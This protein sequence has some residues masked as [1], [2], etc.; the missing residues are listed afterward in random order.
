MD[1]AHGSFFS[2]VIV[3]N[4]NSYNGASRMLQFIADGQCAGDCK[5]EWLRKIRYGLKAKSNPL[6]LNK[7]QRKA[8]ANK[9]KNAASAKPSAR[10][11]LKKYKT[12]SSPPFSAA[13]L[14]GQTMTGNDGNRYIS[15]PNKNNVCSWKQV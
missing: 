4:M 3:Y 8:L 11:T 10:K 7:S 5:R 15:K 2:L 6:S 14:C 9:I 13:L 12:R 1:N